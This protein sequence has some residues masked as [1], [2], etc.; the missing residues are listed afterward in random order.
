MAYFQR[1]DSSKGISVMNAVKD[2]ELGLSASLAQ[3]S[4]ISRG[5]SILD[6]V[7]A[8]VLLG[9]SVEDIDIDGQDLE[10]AAMSLGIGADDI[11]R[12]I[13]NGQL[14]A[15]SHMGKVF[16]YTNMTS[17]PKETIDLPPPPTTAQNVSDMN[18]ELD[19]EQRLTVIEA[20]G[21][22]LVAKHEITML[23]EHLQQAKEENREILRFTGDSMSRLSEL[24]DSILQM[25]DE[26]IRA[27]E[28]QV[29]QLQ[30]R[31]DSQGRELKKLAREK[32][33]LET[34]AKFLDESAR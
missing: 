20:S 4:V 8:D 34:V 5:H 27:R 21:T 3:T 32:E 12:R 6:T 10:T 33:D 11:W 17:I 29:L 13:R 23:L 2:R 7:R 26:L 22:S 24:T 31:L 14:L 19:R 1:L 16:V 9:P 30:E 18:E 15:R 28:D 25:K